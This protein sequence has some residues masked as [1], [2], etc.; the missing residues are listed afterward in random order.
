MKGKPV[1]IAVCG[2]LFACSDAR[3]ALYHRCPELF[4]DD[5]WVRE[6]DPSLDL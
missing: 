2:S 4:R 5:D 6:A 1:V 3:E